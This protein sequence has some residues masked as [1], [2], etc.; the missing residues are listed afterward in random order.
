MTVRYVEMLHDKL[1]SSCAISTVEIL[2]KP[3]QK[4]EE[5]RPQ[6]RETFGDVTNLFVMKDDEVSLEIKNDN[7]S[8]SL[9]SSWFYNFQ[10]RNLGRMNVGKENFDQIR[11]QLDENFP[12]PSSSMSTEQSIF[13]SERHWRPW[14]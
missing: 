12:S 4:T 7:K 9:A 13:L 11:Q 3:H 5:Y 8:S 14:F 10:H 6:N 1:S 2:R